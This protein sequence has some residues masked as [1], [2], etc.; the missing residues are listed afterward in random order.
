MMEKMDKQDQ[1]I[2]E[3][4]KQKKE[5]TPKPAND[6]P[7]AARKKLKSFA[8]IGKK[9]IEECKI[10]CKNCIHKLSKFNSLQ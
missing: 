5:K 6:F 9:S 7:S 8:N 3:L 1:I 10:I 2:A 4:I